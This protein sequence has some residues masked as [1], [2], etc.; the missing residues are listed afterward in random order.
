MGSRL[1]GSAGSL[2]APA[3]G[4][5]SAAPWRE[6]TGWGLQA[7]SETSRDWG[8]PETPGAGRLVEIPWT[9]SQGLPPLLGTEPNPELYSNGQSLWR[10]QFPLL[11]KEGL[12][13]G[14]T[15]SDLFGAQVSTGR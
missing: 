6:Q 4:R 10:P 2:S 11:L 12:R 13:E 5:L 8:L 15:G 9:R 1:E 3:S 7:T 14:G